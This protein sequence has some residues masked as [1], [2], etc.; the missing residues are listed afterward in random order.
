MPVNRCVC[1]NVSFAALIDLHEQT[2]EDFDALCQKTGCGNGCGV[3]VPYAHAAIVTGR[4]SLPVSSP[5][6]LMLLVKRAQNAKSKS[7]PEAQPAA[8]DASPRR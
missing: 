5:A 6:Q 2:G 8:A 1:R 3:C 4:A 7:S